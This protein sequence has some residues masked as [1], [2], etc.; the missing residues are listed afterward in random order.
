MSI[1][2][3]CFHGKG[4]EGQDDFFQP[5]MSFGTT[6]HYCE[7]D[8]VWDNNQNFKNTG[9]NDVAED[10]TQNKLT[11]TSWLYILTA[12]QAY[13]LVPIGGAGPSWQES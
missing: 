12:M 9:R 2:L 6:F 1:I 13:T 11:Q 8:A 5:F 10:K 4:E 3:P 7:N